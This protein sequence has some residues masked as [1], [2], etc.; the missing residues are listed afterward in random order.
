MVGRS[1]GN[2]LSAWDEYAIQRSAM[3]RQFGRTRATKGSSQ[4][5]SSGP[6]EGRPRSQEGS[7]ALRNRPC[8]RIGGPGVVQIHALH[9]AGKRAYSS[10]E[11]K[12]VT[13]R[14]LHGGKLI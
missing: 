13:T 8:R 5:R 7:F 9:L 6:R 2:D 12:P 1:P 4:T 3:R 11:D 10:R 14:N